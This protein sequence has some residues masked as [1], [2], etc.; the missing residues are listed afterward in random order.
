MMIISS[1]DSLDQLNKLSYHQ[2]LESDLINFDLVSAHVINNNMY[3][4]LRNALQIESY[5]DFS[6]RLLNEYSTELA[7]SE[8]LATFETYAPVADGVNYYF[9]PYSSK[10]F[11]AQ[12]FSNVVPSL[13]EI[14]I[15][16]MKSTG[17]IVQIGGGSGKAIIVKTQLMT[18]VHFDSIPKQ[19]SPHQ[20]ILEINNS[21]VSLNSYIQNNEY[22]NKIIEQK[23]QTIADLNSQIDE[24]N[25]KVLSVYQTTWR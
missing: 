12:F 5:H 21:I 23:D 9:Y 14:I 20:A 4:N 8:T 6:Y 25:K 1:I 10:D 17:R 18:Q 16:L 3:S 11:T 19:V 7:T 15:N 13:S 2:F 24:L 22:L